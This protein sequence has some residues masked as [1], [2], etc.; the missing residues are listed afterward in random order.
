[1]FIYFGGEG[2][3][4]KE[5]HETGSSL[6]AVSTEPDVGLKPM[7]HKIMT[8]AKVRFLTDWAIQLH[9]GVSIFKDFPGDSDL[10]QSLGNTGV[11]GKFTLTSISYSLTSVFSSHMKINLP[12]FT[13]AG[14]YTNLYTHMYAEYSCNLIYD[15]S[16]SVGFSVSLLDGCS[17][18]RGTVSYSFHIPSI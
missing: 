2:P 6:W 3:R 10:Q 8:W 14:F 16:V 5:I 1:M 15:H 11:N 9:L 13:K 12:G 17:Q 7:D 4:Q 18:S